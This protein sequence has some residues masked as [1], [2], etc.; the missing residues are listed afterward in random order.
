MR[1]NRSSL[2]FLGGLLIAPPLMAQRPDRNVAVPAGASVTIENA[3]G[4]IRVFAT[5]G[6][7]LTVLDVSGDLA[8]ELEI[9]TRGSDIRVKASSS[10]LQVRVPADAKLF[11]KNSSGSVSISGM[12][13]SV[14]VETSSGRIE[15]AGVVET[16]HAESFSGSITADGG[17][18]R[19]YAESISGRVALARVQGDVDARSTSGAVRVVGRDI[20]DAKLSS[21][22]GMVTFEGTLDR[23]ARLEAESSSA[24]VELTIPNN[25]SAQY[26]LTSISGRI[27]NDFG[28]SPTPRRNGNGATLRFS[29]GGGAHI[30]AT[31]VSGSVRL[32]A[33]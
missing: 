22:S 21:V 24:S 15:V 3:S 29:T 23:N 1:I 4:T 14:E 19:T 20:K 10:Y 17:S 12:R 26:D 30:V 32:L 25:F 13:S 31:S 5:G 28:P 8:R 6:R 27:E 33:L 16:L 7:E 9:D 2:V 18:Q 11:V